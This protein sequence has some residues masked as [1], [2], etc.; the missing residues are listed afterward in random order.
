MIRLGVKLLVTAFGCVAGYVLF[1]EQELRSAA[2]SRVD[3]LPQV[4]A[5]VNGERYAE[6][7]DYLR[8][9]IHYDYVRENPEA[10]D[11]FER[12]KAKRESWL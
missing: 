6:A 11:L 1:A 12:V 3:P 8:F 10:V 4:Q 5:F 2:L 9:F 7:A